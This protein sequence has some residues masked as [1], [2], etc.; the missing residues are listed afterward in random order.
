MIAM[1]DPSDFT[2]PY[3]Q[4]LCNSLGVLDQKV[5][6]FGSKP[7]LYS[8]V[9]FRY[10]PHFYRIS[11]RL[12]TLP[13]PLYLSIKGF[14]HS[15]NMQ[16][17]YW[18]LRNLQPKVI[19]FQWLPLPSLD[20][21][22]IPQH[23]KLAPTIMTVHDT[24]PF[25]GDPSNRLQ[26]RGWLN[27]LSTFDHL[28]VHT[29]YSAEQLIRAGID[30]AKI[31]IVPIGSMDVLPETFRAPDL[32]TK[33]IL[34]FGNIKPYKG[35]DVLLRAVSQFEPELRN[36]VEV[37][38]YG[39]PIM[40]IEPM[41]RLAQQLGIGKQTYW[42][43][44]FIEDKEVPDIFAKANVVAL[45]YRAIDASG[46]LTQALIYGRPVVASRLGGLVDFIENGS[47]GYLVPP[48]NPEA[49]SEALKSILSDPQ[50]QLKMAQSAYQRAQ[51]MPT[52]T[53]IGKTTLDVYQK[54]SRY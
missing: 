13:K 37:Y 15:Y 27:S 46:V 42:N 1:I 24:Q 14:E 5:I 10:Q 19:H 29:V 36:S 34:F 17:L 22:F 8:P 40:D 48:E 32:E 2:P 25:N 18:N 26:V 45:P 41:R 33:V 53:Q 9:S 16:T 11:E 12:R 3:N 51:N 54:A 39:R 28:I 21:H 30:S 44:R 35:L 50:L 43:L 7:N 23:K 52:W 31:S 20:R 6:L 47:T 4:Q 38:I 49:L